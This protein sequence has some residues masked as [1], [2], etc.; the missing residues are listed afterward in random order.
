[1]HYPYS[2]PTSLLN[3]EYASQTSHDSSVQEMLT[4]I[5]VRQ[6]GHLQYNLLAYHEQPEQTGDVVGV[7][8]EAKMQ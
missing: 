6:I 4:S 1:M 2:T 7:T 5:C 8:D 3:T